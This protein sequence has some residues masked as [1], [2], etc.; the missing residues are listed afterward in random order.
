M[1]NQDLWKELCIADGNYRMAH[2]AGRHDVD[3][4]YDL[5]HKLKDEFKGIESEQTKNIIFSAL[6]VP[7]ERE[8]ALDLISFMDDSERTF[9]LEQLVDLAS[10]Q[11]G[12]LEFCQDMIL[13]LPRDYVIK[14]IEKIID[15]ILDV[16]SWEEY[17]AM[18]ILCELL[19]NEKLAEKYM[20]RALESEDEE[21]R[22]IGRIH[23][24]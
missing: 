19:D 7:S 11:N 17:S 13:E 22:E 9:F 5:Y 8:L 21:I 12:L 3:L 20:R 23:S 2:R 10:F 14:N 1:T 16:G 4:S 24:E 6:D 15:R 18:I